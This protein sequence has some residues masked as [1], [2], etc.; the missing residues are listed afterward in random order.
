M[1]LIPIIINYTDKHFITIN[2]QMQ[3][4]GF[5]S[6]VY[7][8]MACAKPILVVTGEKELVFNF[9]KGKNC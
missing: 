1:E 8:I 7:T 2:Q 4:E 5:T 6:K 9:L 3:Q